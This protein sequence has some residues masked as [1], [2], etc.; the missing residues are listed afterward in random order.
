MLL[1]EHSVASH[2]F[3]CYAFVSRFN[4][5]PHGYVIE[6]YSK[7]TFPLCCHLVYIDPSGG[8]AVASYQLI[9]HASPSG[10][11]GVFESSTDFGSGVAALGDLDRDDIQDI[12]VGQKE[13][14]YSKGAVNI[15]FMH[16]DGTVKS[17]QMIAYNKGGFTG[18][19]GSYHFGGS[20]GSI[21]DLNDDGNM[22][23]VVG[24]IYYKTPYYAS[25]AAY[26][27]FLNIDGSCLSHQLIAD[28]TGGFTGDFLG[29]RFGSS[30]DGIG[31]LNGDGILDI[32]VGAHL[33]GT[34]YTGAVHIIFMQTDG[35]CLSHQR[36]TPETGG[37][38]FVSGAYDY[39]GHSGTS[40]GDLN[41]D[42][43]TDI[44]VG[45]LGCDSSTTTSPGAVFMIFLHTD[46]TGLS[47]Q[48]ISVST[49]G[50]TGAL[51]YQDYFGQSVG[52]MGDLNED[53]NIDILVGVIYDDDG[54][55]NNGAIYIIFL[56]SDGT[57]LSHLKISETSDAAGE[58]TSE[59]ID[60]E[61]FGWSVAGIGDLNGDGI[62]DFVV[63][64]QYENAGGYQTGAIYTVFLNG[65][66]FDHSFSVLEI[67]VSS[68]I[69]LISIDFL[70]Q[71]LQI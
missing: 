49:G 47:H 18:Y 60:Y 71:I 46:G 7:Y 50:F 27:I 31:D 30:V 55:G 32:L 65:K 24:S 34:G 64:D 59:F 29:R 9:S 10:Y 57:C 58:L 36:I 67:H 69:I 17:H 35:T 33:E 48:K 16:T 63:G 23:I 6:T 28:S 19:L 43:N 22:D 70:N 37:L 2:I 13:Y 8:F 41:G 20:V 56:Q 42:N 1:Y 54:G 4:S 45:C 26:V 14:Y 66:L 61:S 15:I 68:I 38:T 39:F 12:V 52:Q 11:T 44:A 62:L 5:C 3:T 53:G 40:M 21:G 51:D 25:G